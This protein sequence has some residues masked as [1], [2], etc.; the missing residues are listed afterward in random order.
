MANFFKQIET[1]KPEEK[2]SETPQEVK[3]AQNDDFNVFLFQN[4]YDVILKKFQE[5]NRK[6]ILKL[7]EIEVKFQK[8]IS[9]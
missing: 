9:E 3:N 4:V 2:K 6:Y 8:V 5:Q 7:N 1:G